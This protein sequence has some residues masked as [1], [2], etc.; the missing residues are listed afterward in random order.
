MQCSPGVFCFVFSA[1]YF[2][3]QTRVSSDEE[4]PL[5]AV[6]SPGPL[7]Q[8]CK[9]RLRSSKEHTVAGHSFSHNWLVSSSLHGLVPQDN[10]LIR[11]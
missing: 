6:E 10:A 8:K 7:L 9:A 5:C 4:K 1:M 2:S 11:L 3:P